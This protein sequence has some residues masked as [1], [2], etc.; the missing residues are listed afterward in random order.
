M[1][2]LRSLPSR[3]RASHNAKGFRITLRPVR[4]KVCVPSS[5]PPG[6]TDADRA[7]VELFD[8]LQSANPVFP[9]RK[10]AA[11]SIVGYDILGLRGAN[12]TGQTY[13][14]YILSSIIQPLGLNG[15]SFVKPNDSVGV[16]PANSYWD[17]DVGVD[18]P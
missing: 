2:F 10:T 12:V 13:E 5:S 9:S 6:F 7:R 8:D 11:D 15:T 3:L 4:R 14:D 18:D 16:I 17:V 1:D